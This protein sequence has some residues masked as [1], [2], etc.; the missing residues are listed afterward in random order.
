MESILK[1]ENNMEKI[2]QLKDVD[3]YRDVRD[4]N[5]ANKQSL[6]RILH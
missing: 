2:I 1:Q 3:R 6:S 5:D 4:V